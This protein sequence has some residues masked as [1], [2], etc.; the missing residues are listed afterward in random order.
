VVIVEWDLTVV[1][2][3]E[4]GERQLGVKLGIGYSQKRQ[5]GPKRWQLS[6]KVV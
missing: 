4:R 1:R 3:Q 5:V 2:S 6:D